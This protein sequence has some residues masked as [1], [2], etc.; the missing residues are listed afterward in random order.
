MSVIS[1]LR[2]SR[3]AADRLRAGHLWAYRSDLLADT[4]TQASLPPGS[5]VT[6]EDPAGHSLGTAIY[7][8]VSQIA[9]RLVSSTPRLGRPQYLVDLGTRIAEAIARRQHTAPLDPGTNAQRL[10]FSEA[11]DLPGIIADRYAGLVIVQLLTQATAQ[12][13][14]RT[15]LVEALRTALSPNGEPLTVVERPDPRIRELENLPAPASG[16]LFHAGGNGKEAPTATT[17]RLNG[18]QFHYDAAAGQKTG[19]FLDQRLNYAAAADWVRRS[20]R[21]GHAL[22][23]CT[24]HGGFALH[25]AGV[26]DRVTGVD[27]SRAALETA[28]RNRTA[29]A[30]LR[31]E[32]DWLEADAFELLR[33]LDEAA[34][35]APA[36]GPFRPARTSQRP[37][38]LPAHFDAVVLDPPAFA[39]SK[40][41]AE[42]ALRGYKELNLRALR[43]LTPGGTLVT[44]SCSHHVSLP[45][46]TDIVTAAAADAG[47]RVQLLETRAATPD[48]PEILTLPETRYLKCLVCRVE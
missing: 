1:N 3:R 18:L 34:R 36:A 13:D 2:I 38:G 9:L 46:F 42:G 32:T 35:P 44:C 45:E 20:G 22:D 11:D 26:C 21:T 31:G 40:R 43:L 8:S 10:I 19:A 30:G 37:S 41:A 33:A 14:V 16:P 28:D 48:H 15:A 17:F 12:D 39:K 47:R 27:Q 6:V 24:Y 25:L 5:L 7:S 29:N 4:P 23:V